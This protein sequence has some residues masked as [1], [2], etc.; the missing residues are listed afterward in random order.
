MEVSRKL[1]RVGLFFVH[2]V[3]TVALSM[4]YARAGT[5]EFSFG[6]SLSNSNYGNGSYSWNRRIG[7]SVGYYFL[8]VTELEVAY[9]DVVDQTKITGYQDTTTHDII[10][11]LNLVQMLV[12][13]TFPVQP[14]LKL[15][16]G[17]LYRE[18]QGT[19]AG[20]A[21]PPAVLGSLTVIAGGGLKIYIT[22]AFAIRGEAVSYMVGGVLS[23][24]KDN[25]GLTG[26]VSL[27]F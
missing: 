12:P 5:F 10:V 21:A 7:G 8:S 16:A 22:R 6:G 3:A 18:A 2:L 13:K 14:Y 1:S 15:G 24:W 23:T 17:Q 11:S 20:G 4:S 9:Q 26:G 25:F 27:M 19:Y